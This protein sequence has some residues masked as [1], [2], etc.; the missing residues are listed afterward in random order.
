MGNE[1]SQLIILLRF[2]VIVLVP[3]IPAYLLFKALP[4]TADA[5]GPLQGVGLKLSGAFAGYFV[6]ILLVLFQWNK[7]I[8]GP[9][10]DVWE[11]NGRI[12]LNGKP[13]ET[14]AVDDVTVSPSS[15]TILGGGRFRAKFHTEPGSH[16][17][18]DFPSITIGHFGYVPTTIELKRPST[19]EEKAQ[20]TRDEDEY[21]IDLAPVSLAKIPPYLDKG[22]P[23][24]PVNVSTDTAAPPVAPKDH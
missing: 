24:T 7:I 5:T 8:P 21:R 20:Q 13:L 19:D 14:L 17:G 16:G 2:V 6:I 4:S 9:G 22:T 10:S 15:L 1:S 12:M 23:P 11:V 18:T 3:I